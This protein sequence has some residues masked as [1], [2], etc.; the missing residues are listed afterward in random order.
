MAACASSARPQTEL[1]WAGLPPLVPT[2][3][4]MQCL[5]NA[6]SGATSYDG[7][8]DFAI[9]LA[10]RRVLHL[11]ERRGSR[12]VKEGASQ[13]LRNGERDVN[14]VKWEWA[15]LA[16]GATILATTH[17]GVYT[18][19]SLP[20]DESQLDTLVEVAS[21]LRPAETLRRASARDICASLP[22]GPTPY[23]VAAAFDSTAASVVKWHE[24]PLSP[25][26]PRP[27][28][29]WRD[30]PA[31]ERVAVCYL[32]GDF[33]SA[34]G[35]PPMAGNSATPLPNWNRVVY[36]VGADRR[37]I[38]V[39]FGWQDRIPIRDPGP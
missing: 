39:V 15:T 18:E 31:T 17:D 20:G 5:L 21:S 11:Y 10:D 12:P 37:P 4:S 13:S 32:D 28:S 19:L 2:S 16:N 35:P 7:G 9:Q 1:D 24:T 30:H 22:I 29:Q 36:L 6:V 3:P 27:V 25:G 23:V 14:G 8:Y 34:K 26:G 38:G 33:G